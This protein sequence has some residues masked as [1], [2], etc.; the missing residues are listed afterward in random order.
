[1]Q[2][3]TQHERLLIT[4]RNE[5]AHF[6]PQKLA[7]LRGLYELTRLPDLEVHEGTCDRCDA[8]V[9][10]TFRSQFARLYRAP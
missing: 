4:T 2:Y 8:L 9:Q 5:W 7:R 3:C 10:N 1:M 6:P